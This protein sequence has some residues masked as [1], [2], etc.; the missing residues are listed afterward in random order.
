MDN[1]ISILLV[2]DHAIVRNGI[3]AM[4]SSEEDFEIIG[5]GSDGN[6]AIS[7]ILQHHPDIVIMDINMPNLNGLDALKKLRERGD[8]TPCLIL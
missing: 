6:E 1:E 2:D 3:K 8:L 4:L 7:L 5:E